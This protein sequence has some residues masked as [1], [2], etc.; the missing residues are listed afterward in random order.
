MMLAL[1][2]I[3]IL[4][5]PADVALR[6]FQK[7]TELQVLWPYDD[8]TD[9]RTNA[10]ESDDPREALSQM[11]A[12]TTLIATWGSEDSVTIIVQ[13]P[14][15]QNDGWDYACVPVQWVAGMVY[16]RLGRLLLDMGVIPAE[17]NYCTPERPTG[18]S[19]P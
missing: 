19:Q 12:D 11:L 13:P 10:A 8:I 14:P 15:F 6:D 5:G 16:N 7:Q 9:I 18:E 17:T 4:A 3:S 1:A 2:L